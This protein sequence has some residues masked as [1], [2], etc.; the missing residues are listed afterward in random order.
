MKNGSIF[1]FNKDPAHKLRSQVGTSISYSVIRDNFSVKLFKSSST[2]VFS[3]NT[4]RLK[5]YKCCNK[6]L[7]G[8]CCSWWYIK[9]RCCKT[10]CRRSQR[11]QRSETGKE[12]GFPK[13]FCF[14]TFSLPVK[15]KGRTFTMLLYS[16]V[17]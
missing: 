8:K 6:E 7:L 16:L 9:L 10:R 15:V 12:F 2:K 13:M 11:C 14:F 1:F 5:M 4:E 17:K 3:K